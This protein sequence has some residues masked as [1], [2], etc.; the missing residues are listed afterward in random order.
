MSGK[1]TSRRCHVA[2]AWRSWYLRTYFVLG[3]QAHLGKGKPAFGDSLGGLL[4]HEFADL[5]G[6]GVRVR[7]RVRVMARARARIGVAV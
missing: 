1:P 6:V 2:S 7:V 3:M 4:A 5:V